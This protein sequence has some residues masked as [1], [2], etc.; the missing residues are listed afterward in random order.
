MPQISIIIPVYNTGRYIARCIESVQRQ[1]LADIEIII[2]DD[3]SPDNAM[4]IA[5]AYADKDSRIHIERHASNQGA[6]VARRTGYDAATG[7]YLIFLDSDDTLPEDSL[8]TLYSA[9]ERSSARIVVGG[10]RYIDS[11]GKTTSHLPELS[12]YLHSDNVIEECLRG[13]LTHNLAFGIFESSL[14]DKDYPAIP[15][16]SNGEDL[17]LFYQL[18]DEAG[19]VEII[20][21]AIYDYRQNQDST[22]FTPV[23]ENRLQQYIVCQNFK[24]RFCSR[25]SVDKKV[26]FGNIFKV[27][28]ECLYSKSGKKA[29]RQLDDR[30]LKEVTAGNMFRYLPAADA[31]I[32]YSLMYFGFTRSALSFM[33]RILGRG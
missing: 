3:C 22:S 32:M 33:R 10:H 5:E 8:A 30:I 25:L 28:I 27:I 12:G 20:K 17:M 11:N 13:R 23:S 21:E 16:Q 19:G 26:L 15:H 18:V 6:M 4:D 7:R 29:T 9:I 24:Y 1:S 31:I 2:V 14:F